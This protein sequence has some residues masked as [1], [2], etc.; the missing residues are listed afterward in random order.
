LRL[1][2]I[3]AIRTRLQIGNRTRELALFN[4]ALDSKLP[5]CDLIKLHVRDI[6]QGDRVA[7]RVIVMQQKTQRPV[8]FE[9]PERTRAALSVWI[10]QANLESDDFLFPSGLHGFALY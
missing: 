9:I 2:D 10:R 7:A 6:M 4:L 5:S 1:K 8:L 3:G